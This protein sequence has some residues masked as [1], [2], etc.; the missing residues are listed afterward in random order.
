MSISVLLVDDHAMFR[1]GLKL[2][3]ELQPDIAVIG[4]AADGREAV[5]LVRTLHPQTVLMDIIMPELNGIDATTQI[6]EFDRQIKVI[7]LSMYATTEHVY[8]SFKAGADGYMLKELAG[9]EVIRA[10]RTVQAG[11]RYL[12]D[13]IS[14]LMVA[15]YI[16]NREKSDDYNPLQLLSQREREVLQLLAE[17]KTIQKVAEVLHLAH[18][19]V[20]T[21]RYRLMQKLDIADLHGLVKF[22]LHHGLIAI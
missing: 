16:K 3:L 13:S 1:E 2:L 19:T 7:V 6:K 20:E 14:G 12:C 8:Q 10:I 15:D 5:R 21:Y 22:A 4:Q 11:Q 9:A 18:S 17:G